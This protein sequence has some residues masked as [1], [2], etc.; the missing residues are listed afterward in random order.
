MTAVSGLQKAIMADAGNIQP[1]PDTQKPALWV[2]EPKRQHRT[3]RSMHRPGEFPEAAALTPQL[4][5][6]F[7]ATHLW[8]GGAARA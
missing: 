1:V 4:R 5:S 7:A 8:R 2:G 3:W 6:T